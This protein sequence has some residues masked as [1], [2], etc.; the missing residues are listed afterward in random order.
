MNKTFTPELP[1]EVLER[2]RDYAELFRDDFRHTSQRSWSGVD[3]RGLLQNGEHKSIEPMV[4]RVSRPPELLDIEDPEP[5]LQQ[6]VNQSPWDEQKVLQ[7]YRTTMAQ[8]SVVPHRGGDPRAWW[9]S[10][11]SESRCVACLRPVPS[12]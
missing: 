3:L 8:S 7:R 2:L 5:A 1:P 4:A 10:P 12:L 9:S 11:Q 6:F